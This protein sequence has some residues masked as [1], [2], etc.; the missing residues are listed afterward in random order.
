MKKALLALVV[1]ALAVPVILVGQTPADPNTAIKD[2]GKSLNSNGVTLN[3]ILLNDK[4]IEVLFQAPTKFAMRARARMATMVY[5]QGTPGKDV[6]FKTDFTIQQDGEPVA[7]KPV[8]IKNFDNIKVAKGTR[9]DGV[10]EFP[11]KV[12]L[13]KSF[14]VANG[15]DTVEFK[16]SEDALKSLGS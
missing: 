6:D 7:G 13:K 11:T 8:N 9:I 3:V 10:V 12:D 4:T 2:F 5:V 16:L 14:K 15:K 1:A